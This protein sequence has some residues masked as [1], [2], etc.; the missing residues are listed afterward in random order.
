[1]KRYS[2]LLIVMATML[3]FLS[4]SASFAVFPARDGTA[5][6]NLGQGWWNG[7]LAWYSCFATNDLVTASQ[8]GLTLA[9]K[10]DSA[11]NT[12]AAPV[13]YIVTNY[14]QGPIFSAAPIPSPNTYTGLWSVRYLTWQPGFTR[15]PITNASA[16]PAGVSNT[17][18]NIVVDCPIFAI[19]PVS[20]PW[21][22]P[23]RT[24]PP[25]VYR[26]PQGIYVN[27][28]TKQLTVPLWYVYCQDALTKKISVGQVIIPDA[29]YSTLA[30]LIGANFATNLNQ[31]TLDDRGQMVAINWAQT[32]GGLP[33]K[34]LANQYPVIEDCPTALSWR[35]SNQGY[36]PTMNLS[37]LNRNLAMISPEVLFNNY[38][39]IVEQFTAGALTD[40]VIPYY[41]PPII[42]TAVVN[43]PIVNDL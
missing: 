15:V 28:Y 30:D 32:T 21:K 22:R 40:T 20:N 31:L 43:A 36:T 18:T 3:V 2:T 14:N 24:T 9:V 38:Q 34:L 4:A 19:G 23:S 26:I 1:M 16:I 11:L 29:G 35:N 6:V 8:N 25:Y 7:A 33:V 41:Y 10:L 37:V 39:F 12:V 17:A 27:T 5:V 13:V 42:Q